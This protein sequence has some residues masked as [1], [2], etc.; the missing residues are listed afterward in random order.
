[1]A[2][3]IWEVG[4]AWLVPLPERGEFVWVEAIICVEYVTLAGKF[5]RQY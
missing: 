5:S 1:V 3:S 4:R 2:N